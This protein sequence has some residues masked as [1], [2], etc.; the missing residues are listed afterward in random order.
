MQEKN[1]TF[2]LSCILKLG[3]LETWNVNVHVSKGLCVSICCLDVLWAINK[4]TVN[5]KRFSH[6]S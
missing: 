6:F 3:I 2:R 5:T 4:M 1:I